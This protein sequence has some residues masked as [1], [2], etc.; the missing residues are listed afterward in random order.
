MLIM[1]RGYFGVMDTTESYFY[2][3]IYISVI[4]FHCKIN[5]DKKPALSLILK[6]EAHCLLL[7]P[8]PGVNL[9]WVGTANFPF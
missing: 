9:G 4:N 8:V 5:K 7:A 1:R 2:F 3:S 6:G